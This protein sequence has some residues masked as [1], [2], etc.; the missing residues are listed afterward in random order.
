[1]L[2]ALSGL[3]ATR[4]FKSLTVEAVAKRAKTTHATFY[5]YFLNMRQVLEAALKSAQ[6]SFPSLD[7]HVTGDAQ[8]ERRKIHALIESVFAQAES[9]SGLLKAL[10]QSRSDSGVLKGL[11]NAHMERL[12]RGW[13]V[14]IRELNTAEL[15]RD[16]DPQRLAELV[17]MCIQARIH[18]A[19]L[20]NRTLTPEDSEL[21]AGAVTRLILRP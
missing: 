17:V 11:W 7:L 10:I 18:D 16:D 4:N 9:R 3:L 13:S 6:E 20:R 5:R 2:S 19:V 14:Y 21:W 12:Q 15:G 8:D 1:M